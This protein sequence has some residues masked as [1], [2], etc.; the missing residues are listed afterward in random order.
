MIPAICTLA[1]SFKRLKPIRFVFRA[2]RLLWPSV[3]RSRFFPC[4]SFKILTS[5]RR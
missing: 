3:N 4:N 5:S 2:R 1:I